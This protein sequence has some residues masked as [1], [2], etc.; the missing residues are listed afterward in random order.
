MDEGAGSKSQHPARRAATLA[1]LTLLVALLA[2]RLGSPAQGA[3]LQ[4]GERLWPGYASDLRLDPGPP[5]PAP[6]PPGAAPPRPLTDD[7]RLMQELLGEAA[8]EAEADGAAERARADHEAALARHREAL[9]AHADRLQRRTPGLVRFAAIEQGVAAAVGWLGDHLGHLFVI[10]IG[11]CGAVATGARHHIALRAIH[12]PRGDRAAHAVSL[13]ANLLLAASVAAQWRLRQEAGG[14][15]GGLALLWGLAFAGMAAQNLVAL[16]RP[17]PPDPAAGDAPS[18]AAALLCAPLYAVMAVLA[19]AYFLLVE[20]YV[21]G[22][23]VYLDKLLQ[24]A[25]LYLQVGLYVW[26]GMLLK[27]TRVAPQ[28]FAALR[29]WRL[30]PELLAALVVALAAIPTAYSGASGI[31]VIAAGALIFRELRDAGARPGLALA[32]T[33]MSG[34]LGVVLSPCLLVV[35]IG[36][37]TMLPSDEL[38]G[39]GRWVYLLTAGLFAA[40]TLLTR[41]APLRPSPEAGA[42]RASARAALALAPH[43]AILLGLLAAYYLLLGSGLDQHSAPAL[44]PLALLGMLAFERRRGLA[45]EPRP[46]AAA[47][48]ET[49]VHIGALLL[50]MAL[51]AGLGGVVERA[52]VTAHVPADFAS[53]AAAMAVL[54]VALVLIGMVMDPY[55]AVILVHASLAK[56]AADAGIA[57]VHFWMVVLVAFELGYLTPPVALNH[58]LARQVI[59]ADADAHAHAH[60]TSAWRRHERYLL[61]ITVMVIA[62]ALVAF[63]PLAWPGYPGAAAR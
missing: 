52:D 35:I 55:G 48:A 53:P 60:A 28:A 42:A 61:P 50:L 56:I 12:G 27:R 8:G 51:S 19:G 11:I 43:A 18:L 63:A 41:T 58:L 21:A 49:S 1:C 36:Y 57:P 9:A 46:A 2:Q 10:L 13:I 7:E 15:D 3:L 47:T 62:L 31:F 20:G 37:L 45:A 33:A 16:A 4:L 59:G 39:W 23:A 29:P 30:S 44:L 5:P 6:E 17:R 24:N 54:V 40:L 22:L 32:A 25:Q 14:D 26:A 38:F 34:S